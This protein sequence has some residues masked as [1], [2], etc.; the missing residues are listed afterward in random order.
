MLFINRCTHPEA[1]QDLTQKV[2]ARFAVH[3]TVY[4]S[5]LL[6]YCV[7]QEAMIKK[8]IDEILVSIMIREYFKLLS[9]CM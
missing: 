2:S 5:R 6:I 1:Q 9:T 8:G 4:V 3:K 7:V